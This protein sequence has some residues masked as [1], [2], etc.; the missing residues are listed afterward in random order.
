[1]ARLTLFFLV[2]FAN[3]TPV[4]HTENIMG[5]NG[6][7]TLPNSPK[8]PATSTPRAPRRLV[9]L[10]DGE[11]SDVAAVLREYQGSAISGK[12]LH[13]DLQQH[14][15]ENVGRC[16]AAEWLGPLGWTRFLWCRK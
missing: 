2:S 11:E 6:T 7:G 1:V 14:A 13:A 8:P 5:V 4:F 15:A 16:V 3:L 12:R 9:L 10:R